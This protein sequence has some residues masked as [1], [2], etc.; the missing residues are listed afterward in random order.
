MINDL[1]PVSVPAMGINVSVQPGPSILYKVIIDQTTHERQVAAS[2]P[3]LAVASV[4]RPDENSLSSPNAV[5][6]ANLR[7]TNPEQNPSVSY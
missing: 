3:T 5:M 6:Q 2:V 1:A 4:A 7:Y